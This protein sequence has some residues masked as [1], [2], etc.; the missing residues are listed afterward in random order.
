MDF[1][2]KLLNS[3]KSKGINILIETCGLF[4]LQ[5]FLSAI[6]PY[7][8]I[9]YFDIK[10]FDENEHKR[11]CGVSN[12]RILDNFSNLSR[13]CKKDNMELLPRIPLIPGITTTKDN[14]TAIAG[15]LKDLDIQDLEILPY[16]PLWFDKC[17]KIGENSPYKNHKK[18]REWMPTHQIEQC[19]KIFSGFEI[20]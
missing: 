14:L 9:I 15:F 10:L 8:D 13:I 3:L 1:L 16:N 19:K 20:R 4:D 5:H 2:S 11:Y 12:R 6:Y 7:L 18:M 17:D